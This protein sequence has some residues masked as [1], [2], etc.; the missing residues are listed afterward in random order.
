V[1]ASPRQ[2]DAAR[3]PGRVTSIDGATLTP[4]LPEALAGWRGIV[5]PPGMSSRIVA[6]LR[7]AVAAATMSQAFQRFMK[8]RGYRTVD[9]G[10]EAFGRLLARFGQELRAAR[11]AIE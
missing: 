7:D 5:G 11:G 8:I 9:L 10:P 3:R 2:A 6:R 4:G 1:A